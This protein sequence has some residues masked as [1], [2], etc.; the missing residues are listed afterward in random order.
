MGKFK[1]SIVDKPWGREIRFAQNQEYNYSGKILEVDDGKNL[2]LQY[3]LNK[4]ESFYMLS[5]ECK[6]ITIHPRT[7][8]REENI[9][10]PG[11]CLRIPRGITHQVF[12]I[13]DARLIEVSTLHS[14][15]DTYR[16][17]F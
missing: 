16:I 3:H 8:K 17:E 9:L 14:D 4:D 15:D 11:D 12:G 2:S 5:G 7:T 6:V 10:K 1:P 13:K